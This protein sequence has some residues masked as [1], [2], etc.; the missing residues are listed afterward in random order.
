MTG[1]Q[2]CALPICILPRFEPSYVKQEDLTED[3]FK[4]KEK[5]KRVTLRTQDSIERRENFR[6]VASTMT[7]DEAKLEASR[8]LECGCRDFFECQLLK[9]I[10]EYEI[11]TEEKSGEKHKRLEEDEHPFIDRNPDKCILCGLCVRACDEIMGITALGLVDR[12]FDTIVKPEFGMP[13]KQSDCI[14]CGQCADVCPVGACMDREAVKKQVPLILDS[15]KTTCSYCSVG[16]AMTLD[17]KS[18]V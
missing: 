15:G 14:S 2:T 18:V 12:G 1:V 4:D 6:E 13:L 11:D 8:C 17:R 9:Y 3:D 7:E 16:C 5:I 10:H